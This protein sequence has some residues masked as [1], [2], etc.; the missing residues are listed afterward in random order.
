MHL[1]S[2]CCRAF[3]LDGDTCKSN[4]SSSSRVLA[5]TF[6]FFCEDFIFLSAFKNLFDDLNTC[7]RQLMDLFPCERLQELLVPILELHV[8]IIFFLLVFEQFC[9]FLCFSLVQ[10]FHLGLFLYLLSLQVPKRLSL[11]LP[12]DPRLSRKQF[13]DLLLQVTPTLKLDF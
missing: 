2:I 7:G 10:L 4:F 9:R 12:Q 13:N 3:Q 8:R 5:V 11:P 1:C 6:K